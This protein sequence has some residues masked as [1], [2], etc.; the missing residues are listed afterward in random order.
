MKRYTPRRSENKADHLEIELNGK[1]KFV[2]TFW[3]GMP[4]YGGR[5]RLEKVSSLKCTTKQLAAAEEVIDQ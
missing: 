2:G 1:G 4:S 5:K 3:K